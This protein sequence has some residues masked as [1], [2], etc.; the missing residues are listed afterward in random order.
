MTKRTGIIILCV[1]L[2]VVAIVFVSIRI[3]RA[4]SYPSEQDKS[5]IEAQDTVSISTPPAVTFVTSRPA[6]P[7]REN[8]QD[9]D[10]LPDDRELSLGLSTTL[11]DTDGDGLT[12]ADEV[13]RWH[14]DP[15]SADT[16]GDGYSDLTEIANGYNPLGE[17]TL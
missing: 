6:P 14:T 15:L 11:A 2:L 4:D 5:P 10:G 8:D 9:R 7:Q 1:L 13:D 16:D 17:G 3:F 12:D